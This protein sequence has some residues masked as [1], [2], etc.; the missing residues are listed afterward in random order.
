[1]LSSQ[2]FQRIFLQT[3]EHTRIVTSKPVNVMK[4]Q[5]F[6][7]KKMADFEG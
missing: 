7:H 2:Q 5:R 4:I 6:V 3:R 1:M